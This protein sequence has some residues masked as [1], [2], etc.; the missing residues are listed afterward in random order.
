MCFDI[1]VV[2]IFIKIYQNIW[3]HRQDAYTGLLNETLSSG[4]VTNSVSVTTIQHFR[5]VQL[6]VLIYA[7]IHHM[8]TW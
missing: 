4:Q 7:L 3:W 8:T 2:N 6:E 1:V 5:L